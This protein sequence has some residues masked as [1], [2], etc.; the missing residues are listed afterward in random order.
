[1]ATITQEIDLISGVILAL[2]EDYQTAFNVQDNGTIEIEQDLDETTG[3][4]RRSI[5][6]DRAG[7]LTLQAFLQRP[8]V[9][10]ILNETA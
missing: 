2:S 1:M 3:E 4:F 7:I 9:C 8:E 10:A 6:L 5:E